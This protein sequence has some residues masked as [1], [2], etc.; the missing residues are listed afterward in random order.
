MIQHIMKNTLSS[1]ITRVE[2]KGTIKANLYIGTDCS[3]ITRVEFK[4]M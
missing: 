4:D 2:F 1:N 3:N